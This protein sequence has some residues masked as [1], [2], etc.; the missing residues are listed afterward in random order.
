VRQIAAGY[1]TAGLPP[2]FQYLVGIGKLAP[3]P[4]RLPFAPQARSS[5]TGGRH[6]G[7]Q[8]PSACDSVAHCD[9]ARRRAW[10][11]GF[12]HHL[13]AG[14]LHPTTGQD[15][16]LSTASCTNLGSISWRVSQIQEMF[17]QVFHFA[18][19]IHTPSTLFLVPPAC[20]SLGISLA[21]SSCSLYEGQH[22]NR[23]R[24]KRMPKGRSPPLRYTGNWRGN[25]R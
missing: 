17:L 23:M 13:V 5:L 7:E 6:T 1:S 16:M 3:A 14:R 8:P 21:L 9:M 10:A 18:R 22:E 19:T 24:R 20:I 2:G 15:D 11:L 12:A 4:P 25:G